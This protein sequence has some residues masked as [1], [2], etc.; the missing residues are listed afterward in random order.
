MTWQREN[1]RPRERQPGL[2][3]YGIAI[4]FL[5][6]KSQVRHEC[7]EGDLKHWTPTL[8]KVPPRQ[9]LPGRQEDLHLPEF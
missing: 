5:H 2:N 7:E 6:Q 8:Q 9:Q 1:Q 3:V 4:F